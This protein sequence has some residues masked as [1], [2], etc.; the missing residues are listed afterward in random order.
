MMIDTLE[1]GNDLPALLDLLTVAVTTLDAVGA[2]H[3]RDL[4]L[5]VV[6]LTPDSVSRELHVENGQMV[7]SAPGSDERGTASLRELDRRRRTRMIADLKDVL[8]IWT[9]PNAKAA[10]F[11]GWE[12]ETLAAWLEFDPSSE[13]P[14]LPPGIAGKVMQLLMLDQARRFSMVPDEHAESWLTKEHVDFSNRSAEAILLAG[15]RLDFSQVMTWVFQRQ[16]LS[17]VH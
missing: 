8:L 7:L 13:T 14:P 6:G 10:S 2:E 1:P 5:H 15:D 12:E 9:W 4:R 16:V 17:S 11:L 3:Y